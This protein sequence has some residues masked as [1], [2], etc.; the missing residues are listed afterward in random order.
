MALDPI[1]IS[2]IVAGGASLVKGGMDFF[3]R[4]G[5]MKKQ[6]AAADELERRFPRPEMPVFEYQIPDELFQNR[7][8]ALS[9]YYDMLLP[10][11]SFIENRIQGA[12]AAGSRA[13]MDA[14]GGGADVLSAISRLYGAEQERMMNVG[15]AG[16]E[17]QVRDLDRLMGANNA[18]TQAEMTTEQFRLNQLLNKWKFEEADPYLFAMQNAAQLRQASL[19]NQFNSLSALGSSLQDFGYMF[20]TIGMN[21]GF[22]G[23]PSTSQPGMRMMTPQDYQ[24]LTE[25]QRGY[26]DMMANYRR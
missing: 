14:G 20:A 5:L 12:T 21:G 17:M 6:A 15:L 2:L 26:V 18:I 24:G 11:Q 1:T 13:I 25:E 23:A 10:G 4:R 22:G 3:G 8:L 19:G 7:D 9:Q 16:A